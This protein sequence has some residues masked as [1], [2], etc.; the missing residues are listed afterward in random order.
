MATEGLL[1]SNPNP[2][3]EQ[4]QLGLSGNLCRCAS[5][6]HIFSAAAKAAELKR[7]GG[8]A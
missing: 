8:V 1:R 4:I 2:T 5:Y 6:R 7:R 3:M